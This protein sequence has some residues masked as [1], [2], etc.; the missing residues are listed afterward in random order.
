MS[1]DTP[2]NTTFRSSMRIG[3]MF[4]VDIYLHI[5]VA[6]IF[7]LVSASIA[8]VLHQWHSDWGTFSIWLTALSTGVLFFFS[9][10]LHEL[11]HSVVARA[12]GVNV[13]RITLFLFGGVAEIRND[14]ETPGD[15]FLIAAAGPAA[16]LALALLFGFLAA[17]FSPHLVET[18][19]T[20]D[21][22]DMSQLSAPASVCMWL[23]AVNFML[24]A[25]NLLPG[26]P[27]D[28]GRLFR[29]ALWWRSGD[30]VS[31]T[32]QAARA[33]TMVGWLIIGFGF[34]QIFSGN[35][36]NGLWMMFIGWFISQ[37]AKAS[38]T[39]VVMQR[40]LRGFD[41]GALMRTHFERVPDNL[42]MRDFVD[43][44]LLR[45]SQRIWPVSRN[46]VDIGYLDT[47]QFEA[48]QLDLEGLVADNTTA[49]IA[50]QMLS[51]A[52]PALD[53]L[54][55]LATRNAPLPVVEDHQVVGLIDHADILRWLAVHKWVQP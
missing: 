45:S 48:G 46:G 27:M 20:T 9:L 26:F 25:F 3:A 12:R 14:P 53:V 28:G 21:V 51:P 10:L 35:H 24:A 42:P 36:V 30:Y 6:I 16:S 8:S 15:E 38:V 29:A 1:A 40:A 41:V 31:A 5:S 18:G 4:G 2:P 47:T 7:M 49:L 39:Q 50:E 11:S 22:L 44:Y 17:Q 13:E 34:L 52:T 55:T 19:A 54:D 37:M 33:G 23:S 43:N 32:Q